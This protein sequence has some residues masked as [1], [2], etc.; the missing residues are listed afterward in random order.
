[1]TIDFTVGKEGLSAN[2]KRRVPTLKAYAELL[3]KVFD[4]G[5]LVGRCLASQ[6]P[7]DPL[8]LLDGVAMPG[9]K[10]LDRE[11]KKRDVLCRASVEGSGHLAL[12]GNVQSS[13][14][15]DGASVDQAGLKGRDLK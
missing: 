15:M 6:T 12:M 14:K 5:F 1:M 11:G 8:Q 3:E 9:P 4:N 13:T 2:N 7:P 10:S